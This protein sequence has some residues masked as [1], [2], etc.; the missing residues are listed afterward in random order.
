M[1]PAGKSVSEFRESVCSF[2][3]KYGRRFGAILEEFADVLG[4]SAAAGERQS[5]EG[6]FA[7]RF[8]LSL[9]DGF[10]AQEIVNMFAV[11][12]F[13]EDEGCIFAQEACF[14]ASE[15]GAAGRAA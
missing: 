1:R 3:G 9:E 8:G 6:E 11:E 5:V 13:T 15:R 12:R 14:D 10:A 4:L 2:W 7:W